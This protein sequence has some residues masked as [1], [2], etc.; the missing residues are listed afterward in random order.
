[1]NKPKVLNFFLLIFMINIITIYNPFLLEGSGIEGLEDKIKFKERNY[2]VYDDYL[3]QHPSEYGNID[4][5]DYNYHSEEQNENY[6]KI[7]DE[8]KLFSIIPS[9][10]NFQD[11]MDIP[12]ISNI[13]S[14][15]L[16]S[17]IEENLDKLVSMQLI[18]LYNEIENDIDSKNES[19][20]ICNILDP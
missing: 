17:L 1:M 5:H 15:A 12:N 14:D 20:T 19:G 8:Q 6:D 4:P 10:S 7:M 16:I 13:D 2:K 3:V 9:T 11:C 18:R